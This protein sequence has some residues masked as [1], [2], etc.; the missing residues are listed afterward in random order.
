MDITDTRPVPNSPEDGISPNRKRPLSDIDEEEHPRQR[1]RSE[2]A[3][4]P[5]E[6][7]DSSEESEDEFNLDTLVVKEFLCIRW[8]EISKYVFS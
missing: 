7:T 3:E 2:N 4:T 5:D 6:F 1:P 8:K